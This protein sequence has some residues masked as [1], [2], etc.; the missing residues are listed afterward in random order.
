MTELEFIENR[1][2]TTIEEFRGS[3]PAVGETIVFGPPTYEDEGEE[4][5]I[6]L[7]VRRYYYAVKGERHEIASVTVVR[8]E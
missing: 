6:V 5:Y 2:N 4:A 7:S 1:N 3:V 8:C